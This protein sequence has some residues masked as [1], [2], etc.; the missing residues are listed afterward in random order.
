[1]GVPNLQELGL[2]LQSFWRESGEDAIRGKK[3]DNAARE[4]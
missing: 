4:G 3:Q 2:L 1:V